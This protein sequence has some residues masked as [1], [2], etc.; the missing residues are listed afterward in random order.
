MPFTLKLLIFLLVVLAIGYLLRCFPNS[1]ISKIAFSWH[2]PKP[3]D[4]E[5]L[6]HYMMRWALYAFKQGAVVFIVIVCGIYIGKEI[7]QNIF[8]NTYFQLFFFFGFPFLVGMAV[9][10]GIGCLAKSAWFTFRKAD[11]RFSAEEQEFIESI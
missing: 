3:E 1:A 9:L 7:N 5:T 4:Q 2:G 6:G 11:F 8:E 10:G